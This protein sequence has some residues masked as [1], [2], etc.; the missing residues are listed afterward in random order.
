[1]NRENANGYMN[2]GLIY[3]QNAQ[4]EAAVADYEK[5]LKL[6]PYNANVYNDLALSKA[7]LRRYDEAIAYYGKAISLNPNQ[8]LFYLNRARTF[9]YMGKKEAM[10]HDIQRA[11]ALGAAIPDD[12][13][14]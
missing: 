8:P 5:Y 12:L 10:W 6:N 4:Y 14:Q 3:F 7:A 2:R 13:I 9:K 11:K 1:M